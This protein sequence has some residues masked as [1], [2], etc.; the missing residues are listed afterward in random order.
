[1]TTG[2]VILLHHTNT[3]EGTNSALK[4]LICPRNRGPAVDSHL[5]E[6][7]WRRQHHSRLWDAFIEAL[8]DIHYEFE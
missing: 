5:S 8:K 7:V 6:F 1:M 4:M 2:E 3:V